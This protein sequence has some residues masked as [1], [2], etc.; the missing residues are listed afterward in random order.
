MVSSIKSTQTWHWSITN[1]KIAGGIIRITCSKSALDHLRLSYYGLVRFSQDICVQAGMSS[2]RTSRQKDM[3]HHHMEMG[4]E[5][6]SKLFKQLD[7]FN[8]FV[9]DCA[10]LLCI[11]TNDIAPLEI[12]DNLSTQEQGK[13]LLRSFIQNFLVH[14]PVGEMLTY[15]SMSWHLCSCHWL[16][17]TEISGR[18]VR[19]LSSIH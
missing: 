11:L 3:G 8:P 15:Q 14:L 18:Q 7:K 5:G 19:L 13:K 16:H 17:L 10:D 9:W 4:E 1:S 12:K 2:G 6:V